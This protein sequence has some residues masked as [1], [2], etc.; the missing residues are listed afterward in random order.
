LLEVG[1]W[2]KVN[3]EAVYNSRPWR[4]AG[5]GPTSV[6]EGGFS[7]A[8]GKGFTPQDIRFTVNGGAL[9]AICLRWPEDGVVHIRSLAVTENFMSTLFHGVIRD[10]SVLGFDGVPEWER[11]AEGLTVR[12]PYV[13]SE[14][15]VVVKISLA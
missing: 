4:V 6:T 12:A 11:G 8:Q 13:C 15:P 5:E 1:Q 14:N 3:G 2:L 10:V 7:D 9:Y